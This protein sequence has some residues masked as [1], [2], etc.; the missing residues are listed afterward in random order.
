MRRRL[1][2]ILAVFAILGC[3]GSDGDTGDEGRDGFEKVF[4]AIE[5]LSGQARERKLVEL[6]KEEGGELSVYTS[7]TS[8]TETAVADAFEE[9]YEDVDVSVYRAKS[10]AV[11]QRVS[12]EAKAGLRGTDALE[13]GGEEMAALNEE[14]LFIPYRSPQLS[15]LIEGSGHEGWTATRYNKFVVSWNTDLVRRGRQP[16]SWEELADPKWKGKI[17]LEE[18]D[19]DW[20]RS[21]RE[22]WIERDGKSEAEADRLFEDIARNARIVSSHNLMAQLLAAGEYAAAAS[23]YIHLARDTI[24]KG[25][26]V[27]FDPL[28]QPVFSRPQGVGLLE[29]ARHP[30]AAILYV[31]WLLSD[32]QKVLKEHNVEPARKDLVTA[33]D[34]QEILIDVEEFVAEQ[35]KWNDRFDELLRLGEKVEEDG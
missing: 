14:G 1:P 33:P 17:A 6:A 30:A 32:G 35:E 2:T 5:G 13:T 20:Y 15:R 9:A 8:D 26:P 3:G 28:V 27:S 7:L 34:A 4:S 24:D 11:A 10:E 25:A 18:S 31:D 22:Y 29:T 19:A 23:S 21:L 16:R 12:E